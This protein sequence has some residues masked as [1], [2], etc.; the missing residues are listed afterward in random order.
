MR[1]LIEK[2]FLKMGMDEMTAEFFSWFAF[3]FLL[4]FICVRIGIG[5]H[6]A[7]DPKECKAYSINDI[8]LSPAYALGCNLAKDRFDLKLN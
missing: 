2:L 1:K 4:I 6:D 3:I 5:V 8:L 7:N